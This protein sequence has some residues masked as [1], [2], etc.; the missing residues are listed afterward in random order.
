MAQPLSNFGAPTIGGY[1]AHN[2]VTLQSLASTNDTLVIGRPGVIS[3][4]LI[5]NHDSTHS[6]LKFYDKATTPVVGT[7]T[8]LATILIPPKGTTGL[9]LRFG[10][11]FALGI[12]FG[13]TKNPA[14]SDTTGVGANTIVGFFTYV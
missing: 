14:I 5:S 4:L 2:I 6:F 9:T 10:L 13:M 3:Q 7:D 12:G 8:P 1:S 11:N